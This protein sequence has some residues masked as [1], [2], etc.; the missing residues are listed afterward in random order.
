MRPPPLPQLHT[1]LIRAGKFVCRVTCHVCDPEMQLYLGG[2]VAFNQKTAYSHLAAK[3]ARDPRN[4]TLAKRGQAMSNI[5]RNIERSW[6][7]ANPS[8]GPMDPY[9]RGNPVPSE[10]QASLDDAIVR[11]LVQTNQS[12]RVVETTSF[13]NLVLGNWNNLRYVFLSAL[14]HS[15]HSLPPRHRSP[16]NSRAVVTPVRPSHTAYNLKKRTR[17]KR[18]TLL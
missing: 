12:Y 4:D 9:V 8:V 17:R 11:F 15:Q 6:R 14:I 3:H 18:L 7:Q 10:D 2:N 16:L 5:F 1:P 13:Q